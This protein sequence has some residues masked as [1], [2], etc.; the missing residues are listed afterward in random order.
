MFLITC[1]KINIF[2]I[3]YNTVVS[4]ESEQYPWKRLGAKG[5]FS[6]KNGL[7]K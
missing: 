1:D 5:T 4:F 3:K 7:Y 6:K 2:F